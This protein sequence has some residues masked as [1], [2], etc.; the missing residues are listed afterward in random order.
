MVAHEIS[1]SWTGNLITNKTWGHFWLNEGWTTWLQRKIMSHPKISDPSKAAG[2]YGLDALGGWKHLM[3]DVA[4]HPEEDTKLVMTLGDG[5]PDD[6]YSG[7]PYEKGF[8]L[9]HC[10][11]VLVGAD[12]FMGF[13][14]A[15]IDKFKYGTVTS[16]EFRALFG[17]YF[18]DKEEATAAA[19]FDWDAWLYGTGMP[20]NPYDPKFDR[21]LAEDAE[22]LAKS[23]LDCDAGGA[24]PSDGNAISSWSTGQK[25]WFLDVVLTAI[26]E[27]SV[28]LKAETVAAMQEVYGFQESRNAE[29]LFRFLMLGVPTAEAGSEMLHIAT[30]FITTQG[31]MKY[32]RPLYRTLR[33][34]GEQSR[35]LAID[36]FLANQDFYHPIA[37]KMLA[38]DLVMSDSK[39][40][41]DRLK[42]L[43]LLGAAAIAA[44]AVTLSLMRGKRR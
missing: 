24:A 31:R 38:S 12:A 14:K 16:D 17:E 42:K 30:R 1:H 10:L 43:L 13:A 5:D 28:P 3:D 2:V 6:S 11:E 18:E 22:A 32:V 37:T 27:R 40:S 44:A 8:N 41:P 33:D 23:W 20:P 19:N 35:A 9:L 26:E 34:S 7:V 29:I 36:T 39:R 15:Y 4:L 21:S 25:T